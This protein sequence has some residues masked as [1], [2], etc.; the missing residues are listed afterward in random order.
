MRPL[1]QILKISLLSWQQFEWFGHLHGTPLANS[2]T[3]FNPVLVSGTSF[4]DKTC[5]VGTPSPP[6]TS[7]GLPSYTLG[8]LYYTRFPYY[9]PKAPRFQ[10][11]RPASFPQLYLLSPF[12]P[13]PPSTHT[14]ATHKI[15]CTSS[16]RGDPCVLHPSP[17]LY[18]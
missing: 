17:F 10:L 4:V 14:Q 8:C 12:P 1:C 7:L 6:Y 3:E 5:P 18:T 2:S 15:Y 11:L 13:N 16:F 9:P